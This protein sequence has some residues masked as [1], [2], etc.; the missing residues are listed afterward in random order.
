M[1]VGIVRLALVAKV[2]CFAAMLVYV[3]LGV[4]VLIVLYIV[5]LIRSFVMLVLYLR[6]NLSNW[7]FISLDSCLLGNKSALNSILMSG[8]IHISSMMISSVGRILTVKSLT[9]PEKKKM[10]VMFSV[11]KHRMLTICE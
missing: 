6:V 7:F 5:D 9:V 4:S 3:C 11:P 8:R 1:T 2:V 10:N